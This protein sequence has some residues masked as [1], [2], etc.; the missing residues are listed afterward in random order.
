[1]LKANNLS[2]LTNKA[3]ARSNL[4]VY[5]KSESND[6]FNASKLIEVNVATDW[7]QQH[8]VGTT[9]QG[10]YVPKKGDQLL[11]NFVNGTQINQPTLN[12]D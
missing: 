9:A 11:V 2:D 5:S 7:N 8:K 12:I 3:Q 4:E 6:L 10:H 1:M